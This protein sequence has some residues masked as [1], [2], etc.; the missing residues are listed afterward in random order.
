M[1]TEAHLRAKLRKI[2][3]LFA[4]ATTPGERLAAASAL[5]RIKAR[6]AAAAA[7]KPAIEMRFTLP[8]GWSRQLFVALCRRYGLQPYRYKGQR[9]TTVL[10]R[11]PESFVN[12]TLWP[13]YLQLSA[14]LNEYLAAATSRI[15][16]E[17]VY[18]DAGDAAERHSGP[19]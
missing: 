13:E 2:E 15:I 8:D 18:R 4:G 12:Q 3:A 7:V 9:H 11:V 14:A 16:R 5:E 10:L 17:E 6:L 1:T 19:G